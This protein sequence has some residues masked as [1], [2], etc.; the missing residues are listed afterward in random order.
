[1]NLLERNAF[2]YKDGD[3]LLKVVERQKNLGLLQAFSLTPFTF[4]IYNAVTLDAYRR[5]GNN[6]L[7]VDETE[8]RVTNVFPS[9]LTAGT[10]SLTLK[11]L[12][13]GIKGF[14][15]E[16]RLIV[17]E[18]AGE[19]FTAPLIA[20]RLL[21]FLEFERVHHRSNRRPAFIVI[22]GGINLFNGISWAINRMDPSEYMKYMLRNALDLPHSQSRDVIEMSR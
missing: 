8:V 21:L 13:L 12:C 16:N 2:T 6:G 18:C 9:A 17:A 10:S 19:S 1:M 3:E 14:N 7:F 11:S 5:F 20:S 15:N 4:D 22:D